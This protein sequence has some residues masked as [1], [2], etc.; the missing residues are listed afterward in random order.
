[1]TTE[2]KQIELLNRHYTNIEGYKTLRFTIPTTICTLLLG[3][4]A[5]LFTNIDKL[6]K[7][8]FKTWVCMILITI[9]LVGLIALKLV[10]RQYN[11]IAKNIYYLYDKLKMTD[12]EFYPKGNDHKTNPLQNAK[13][14]FWL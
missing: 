7:I 10:Q 11:N 14:I 3:I 12:N 8:E 4:V 6:V 13:E 5:I 2:D 1:M 9:S